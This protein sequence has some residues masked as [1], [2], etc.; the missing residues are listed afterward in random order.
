MLLPFILPTLPFAYTP[1]I[2][3]SVNSV[4]REEEFL[5]KKIKK[6][7]GIFLQAENLL[8]SKYLSP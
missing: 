1:T 2:P 5:F 7:I 8:L 3:S 6:K 4:M